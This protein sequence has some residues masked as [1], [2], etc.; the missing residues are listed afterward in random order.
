MANL[1]PLTSDPKWVDEK[2]LHPLHRLRSRISQYVI[3]ESIL[4]IFLFLISWF[5]IGLAL[6]FGVFWLFDLDWVQELSVSF[7]AG[8]LV[9]IS[10]ALV[11]LI[12]TKLFI[13]LIKDFSARNLA[14]VLE[15]RFPDRFGDRLIT[16][17]EL[18]DVKKASE[19]GY[20]GDMIRKTIADARELVT[21]VPL[22]EVFNWK[23]LKQR[24]L[25]GVG[26]IF[27]TIII[28]ALL[29]CPIYS[30]S[31]SRFAWRFA[32][33]AIIWG[34]RNLL[35]ENSLWPRKVYLEVLDFPKDSNEIRVGKDAAAPK[36]RVQAYRWVMVDSAS[37]DGNRA[38]TWADL[39]K[40]LP[41]QEL[42]DLPIQDIQSL[43]M[44]YQTAPL[45][46]GSIAN[47]DRV[48][49]P[50]NIP[51]NLDQ[52]SEWRVDLIEDWLQGDSE[53][54][55]Y[56][57]KKDAQR[58]A[59]YQE[60]FVELEKQADDPAMS[61]VLRR[62]IIP[63]DVRLTYRGNK[64]WDE[65]N[66]RQESGNLFTATLTNLKESVDLR[67]SAEDFYSSKKHIELVPAPALIELKRTE[68]QP[69]YLGYFPIIDENNKPLFAAPKKLKGIKQTISDL[70]ISLTGDR[71][72]FE[73]PAGTELT[74][75][76]KVDKD[77]QEA[78]LIPVPNKYPIIDPKA[79]PESYW[80]PVPL[81]LAADKRSVTIEFHQANK[82]LLTQN[83][84]FYLFFRDMDN[85]SSKRL[86]Q[87]QPVEDRA[88]DVEVMVET[89][90]KVGNLYLCTP[91]AI[92]PFAKE[93]RIR[94]DHGLNRV[95]FSYQYNQLES[96]SDLVS[97]TAL[98]GLFFH[99][100]PN[101]ISTQAAF[102]RMGMFVGLSNSI[103][104]S[105]TTS[106]VKEILLDRFVEEFT[107]RSQGRL[108][109]LDNLKLLLTNN[110]MDDRDPLI[111]VFD[112]QNSGNV[113]G[114]GFDLDK[115]LPN[116]AVKDPDTTPQPSYIL[117]LNVTATDNNVE[118]GP[119]VGQN[120][121]PL[122]FKVVS[123]VELLGEISREESELSRKLDEVIN[124]LRDG[125][126]KLL[127]MADRFRSPSFNRNNKE[128]FYPEQTRSSELVETLGKTKDSCQEIAIDYTR[129][130]LELRTNRFDKYRPRTINDMQNYIVTPLQK[131]LNEEYPRSGET[132]NAI[133]TSV[134]NSIL[135]DVTITSSAQQ[136][137]ANL[138][139]KLLAIRAKISDS[140]QFD[141]L[142][143][144]AKEIRKQ[145]ETIGFAI[146]G[147]LDRVQADLFAP[148]IVPPKE[149]TLNPGKKFSL[150]LTLE[151]TG[152]LSVPYSL[153]FIPSEESDLLVQKRIDVRGTPLRITTDITA[154]KKTGKFILKVVP[155]VG[156]AVV[157]PI[158]VK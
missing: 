82:L 142:I 141:K 119:K 70:N 106:P 135:P 29:I 51:E 77:L 102:Y 44:R 99:N 80:Q 91:K 17:V 64:T 62:L 74:I 143:V 134:N 59:K 39:K 61:R 147:L 125:Q 111:K 131:I 43:K 104:S 103:R 40:I 133:M 72:R 12:I 33:V 24:L 148:V 18:A 101:P 20:S 38:M 26:G 32:D 127:S 52:L 23:R 100:T 155:S 121:E 157:I 156:K 86:I 5:W 118:T 81:L 50:N 79:P 130:L 48:T 112:F 153:D 35:L 4:F 90:R 107:K 152:E 151:S 42:P 145:Q 1:M 65:M 117:T 36:L 31:M 58:F 92:I 113:S 11:S 129:I 138:I 115:V 47:W 13:R 75:F 7:R 93:S 68:Y 55:Q 108:R 76:A 94:D 78:L 57:A 9:I 144:E 89:L 2:I 128:D 19:L 97:K 63:K 84:E 140:V 136:A 137:L 83:T 110:S 98:V 66:L 16:A 22:G 54:S 53:F 56:L 71:S 120:K 60:V 46:F 154:G 96:D 41:D 37:P 146:K 149:I 6:D 116:L 45:I 15:N 27:G 85:V 124:K 150:V 87:I 67:V 73:I 34:E 21:D 14:L 109:T 8:I 132:L 88:P 114:E 25:F 95:E 105:S 3:I 158:E 123:H 126:Q 10:L 28:L 139:D 69:A 122:L 49:L 30:L